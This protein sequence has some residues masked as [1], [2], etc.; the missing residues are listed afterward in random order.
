MLGRLVRRVFNRWQITGRVRFLT[1][2]DHSHTLDE[3]VD[4][5]EN[6]SCR[7]ASLVLRESVKPLKDSLNVLLS[8][9]LPYEF[10][11]VALSKATRQQNATH[12]IVPA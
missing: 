6:L 7:D 11:Y 5:I 3:T 1:F 10:D 12:S 4:N 8:E 2:H 9:S